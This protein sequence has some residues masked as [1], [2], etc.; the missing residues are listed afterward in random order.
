MSTGTFAVWPPTSFQDLVLPS[1]ADATL[2]VISDGDMDHFCNQ[3]LESVGNDRD[4]LGQSRVF[5]VPSYFQ[6][7]I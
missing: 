3:V 7:H 5:R 1:V 4:L 2:S 6:D